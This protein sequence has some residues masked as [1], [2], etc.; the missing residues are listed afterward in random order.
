MSGDGEE[1]KQMVAG[2]G[3]LSASEMF[4]QRGG[5]QRRDQ[6]TLV[7]KSLEDSTL[8]VNQVNWTVSF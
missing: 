4:V 1:E 7:S 6:V 8:F 5:A 2:Y 3:K